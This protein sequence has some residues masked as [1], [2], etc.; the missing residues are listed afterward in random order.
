MSSGTSVP[1]PRTC[2]TIGPRF[3][4][5]GQSVDASTTGAAGLSRDNPTLTSAM[6]AKR[7]T[8]HTTRRIRF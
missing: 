3:T 5:S 7:P 8:A 1:S 4:V 2:R 6:T